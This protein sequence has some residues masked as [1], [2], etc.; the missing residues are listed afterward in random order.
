MAGNSIDPG[1][2]VASKI[3]SILETF[4]RGELHSLT[5]ICCFTGLPMS[6]VHRLAGELTAYGLLER[7]GDAR[8][9]VGLNLR[10]IGGHALP[11]SNVYEHGRWVLEDLAD[12][13][14]AHV[15]LGVLDVGTVAYIEKTSGHRPISRFC[16]AATVPA[17]A[18]AM[19]KVLLAF[20]SRR[21]VDTVIA[22][23]LTRYTKDTLASP[24]HLRRALAQIRLTGLAVSRREMRGETC[25]IAAP[26]FGAGGGIVC[27][28]E[29]TVAELSTDLPRLVPALQMAARSLSRDL[30]A[31]PPAA[32]AVGSD[33]VGTDLTVMASHG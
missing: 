20:S 2:S 6:T 29:I 11:V 10:V 21:A 9:R 4:S 18:T 31:S 27:A 15:R 25:A 33:A 1:R 22:H 17:H 19:G 28:I 12:S 7:T 30:V 14:G 32:D 5:E 24:E 16:R 13:T 26:V 23:G 8:Y 3:A